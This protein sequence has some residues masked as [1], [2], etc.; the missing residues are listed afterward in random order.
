MKPP[1][2]T[3]P[4]YTLLV[5]TSHKCKR[6]EVADAL[7]VSAPLISQVL[8]G[9]GK[10]ATG[11]AST[12]ELAQKVLHTYAPFACPYLSADQGEEVLLDAAQC[13]SYAHRDAPTTNPLTMQHW[14]ACR[15]CEHRP[16]TAPVQRRPFIKRG[17]R[18]AIPQVTLNLGATS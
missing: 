4:W 6:K 8:N 14:Q 7:G 18:S 13:R 2:I 5:A 12:N 9:S 3:E 1:Y 15:V 10:Y 16:Y 17:S 11:E